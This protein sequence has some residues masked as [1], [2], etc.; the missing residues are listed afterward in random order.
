MSGQ[1]FAIFQC[2]ARSS[3]PSLDNEV[4]LNNDYAC[5]KLSHYFMGLFH[6]RAEHYGV[7]LPGQL[8]LFSFF[9]LLRQPHAMFYL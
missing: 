6:M 1:D 8:F 9:L 7:T 5:L 4:R 2:I 3:A